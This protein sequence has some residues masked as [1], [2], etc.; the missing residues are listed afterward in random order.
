[1]GCVGYVHS[2]LNKKFPH[3]GFKSTGKD[4]KGMCSVY[5]ETLS[6]SMTEE[7]LQCYFWSGAFYSK[8][9]S[10][11]TTGEWLA[12]TERGVGS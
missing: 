6:E 9:L 5:F 12:L 4:K 10:A 11:I 7:F 1:M 2:E 3:I 8:W